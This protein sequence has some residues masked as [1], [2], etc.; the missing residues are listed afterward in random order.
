MSLSYALVTRAYHSADCEMDHSLVACKIRVQPKKFHRTEQEGKS[1]IDVSKTRW[2]NFSDDFVSQFSASFRANYNLPA[3][4]QWANLKEKEG[5]KQ[6][7]GLTPTQNISL[8]SSKPNAE[9]FK[10]TRTNP[11]RHTE[12]HEVC[13]KQHPK[14]REDLYQPILD[15][16]MSDHSAGS[17]HM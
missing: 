5:E 2:S 4:E 7:T 6:L 1:R 15:R 12:V 11:G 17:R 3:T 10:H 14:N 9:H 16:H 13:K 8:L